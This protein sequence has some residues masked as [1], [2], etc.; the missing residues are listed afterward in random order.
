MKK[1]WQ[2]TEVEVWLYKKAHKDLWKKHWA[3]SPFRRQMGWQIPV[4]IIC[5][6]FL[7]LTH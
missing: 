7:L 1:S 4:L 6:L 3:K 5:L 2:E